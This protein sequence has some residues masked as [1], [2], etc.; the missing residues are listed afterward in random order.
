MIFLA[1]FKLKKYLGYQIGAFNCL[2]RLFE[3][4]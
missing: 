2:I 3:T 4:N 1:Y